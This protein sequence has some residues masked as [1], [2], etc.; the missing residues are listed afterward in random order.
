MQA[1]AGLGQQPIDDGIRPDTNLDRVLDLAEAAA[2]LRGVGQAAFAQA[3]AGMPGG[4]GEYITAERQN[5]G[6]AEQ[7]VPTSSQWIPNGPL[8]AGTL[9]VTAD[10]QTSDIPAGVLAGPG[11]NGILSGG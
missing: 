2:G 5:G 9:G 7:R 1:S 6:Y 10:R 11:G 4:I 3:A 8:W